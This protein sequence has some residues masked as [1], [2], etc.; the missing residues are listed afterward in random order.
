MFSQ[1]T[2][3][4]T[5]NAVSY[6][7]DI[8][9]YNCFIKP[10]PRSFEANVT[11]T[12]RALAEI[13]SINLNADNYS[14][15]IDS[16]ALSGNSFLHS[17]NILSV[18]LSRMYDSSEVLDIKIYYRHKDVIDSSFI[19]RDGIVYTDCQPIGARKWFPC[20]DKPSDK[21]LFSIKAK[22]PVNVLFCSNG[23]LADS[24]VADS[25]L[26]YK[27]VSTKP[28]ATYLIVIAGKKDFNLAVNEWTR[29]SDNENIQLRYYSQKGETAFNIN[30]IKTKVPRILD[31]FS[32]LFCE[33]P[34]EKLG[35][36]T[37]NRDF[38]WGGMENQTL[39][40]LCPDCWTEDLVCHEIAHQWFGN[41]ISPENWS[42]IWLNEGFATYCEALWMERKGGYKDYKRNIDY[43]AVKYFARN[44]GR[45]IYNIDWN[46]NVPAD[47]LLFNEYLTYSK[48][49]CIIHMLRYILGDE[50]FFKSLNLYMNNPNYLYGNISTPEFIRF[51]GEINEMNLD[52]FFYEWL[53][54]P[55]HP[56]YQT[57]TEIDKTNSGKWKLDYTINQT[58]TNSSFFKMPVELKIVFENGK[59]SLVKVE[60]AYNVQKYTFEFNSEPSRVSFDPNNQIVLKEVVK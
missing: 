29:K 6:D 16:V 5:F 59:D 60:N 34:F 43:E 17:N 36:V 41:L 49:A 35:F 2:Q 54:Q 37:T 58:Q 8:N 23:M 13:N 31:F 11:V 19:V 10:F 40:T 25:I 45:P 30:N 32:D 33:Y 9:L 3:S 38:Q 4:N 27:W 55:N 28:V 46:T 18:G 48:A 15:I 42:D 20:N 7:L 14:L 21:A 39:I 44:P 26:T 1:E 47:S 56:V 24:T 51:M 22:V 57:R 53:T 50:A 52:W 12:V